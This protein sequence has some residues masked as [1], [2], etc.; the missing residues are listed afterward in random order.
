MLTVMQFEYKLS[1]SNTHIMRD[2]FFK[3]IKKKYQH[4]KKIVLMT[5]RKQLVL[6]YL[7]IHLSEFYFCILCLARTYSN[8]CGF[9]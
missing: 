6:N 7:P 4:I 8:C 3:T 5:L 2:F 9:I 1:I